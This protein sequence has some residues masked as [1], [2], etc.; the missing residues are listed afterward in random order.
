[1][2]A[3]AKQLACKVDHLTSNRLQIS[4]TGQKTQKTKQK[5]P[6]TKQTSKQ[7]TTKNEEVKMDLCRLS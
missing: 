1:M 4:V 7:K 3:V 6:K 5:N 2:Q